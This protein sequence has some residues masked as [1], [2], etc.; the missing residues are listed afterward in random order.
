[1]LE[2]R[3]PPERN[4]KL[5]QMNIA[6]TI[7]ADKADC[8]YKSGEI[9][10][11]TLSA[12]GE[13]GTAV[14]EGVVHVRI[15]NYGARVAEER[16]VDLAAKNPVRLMATRATPGFARISVS[17]RTTGMEVVNNAGNPAGTH[18]FG[19][20]FSPGEIRPGTPYPDDFMDFWKDAVRKLDE[21]VPVDPQ[22][23][24][25]SGRS[26]GSC[27]YWRVSFAT[28][29]GRRVFGWLSEPKAGGR[30]PVRINVPGAGIGACGTWEDANRI[31]LTMNVHS[32]R[33]PEGDTP[34]AAAERQ[35]LY[36]AQDEQ[37]AKPNAVPRYCQ[38]GIH[39]SREDYFYYASILGLNRAVNWLAARPECDLSA[40]DYNGTSQG[41]G[42][43]LMLTA[44]N[45]HITRSC[46]FVPAITD[47]L[48]SKVEGRQSGWPQIIE[49][50]APENRAAAEKWAPYFCGT[51]FARQIRCPI[52]FVV[53]FCDMACAP[54]AVYS[55]Y[56]VCPS[57]D[58]AILHGVG[59]GHGV[60]DHFYAELDQWLSAPSC[61][62]HWTSTT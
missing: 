25:V 56:N 9:A 32:Y 55:A 40:F 20:A 39:K 13:D 60:F 53:G 36:E 23:E 37:Y 7:A 58:K 26:A 34:E 33:Q 51:N 61:W 48:S 62:S 14:R 35:R 2:N 12:F 54:H 28:Y 19:I 31:T 30:H 45:R 29:G 59:M 27:N 52:R 38:A 47:L 16:D 8:V 3:C 44:L 41:G 5:K 49:N 43:G 17:S 46:I 22:M 15:D 21:T 57:T 6:I 11:L 1:M 4:W 10:S 42:F 18:V 24:L 50:Q